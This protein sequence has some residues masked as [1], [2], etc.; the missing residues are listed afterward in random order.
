MASTK[1]CL[2]GHIPYFY[3][4]LREMDTK[5]EMA[6]RKEGR[7]E[8][9]RLVVNFAVLLLSRVKARFARNNILLQGVSNVCNIKHKHSKSL[10]LQY[11]YGCPVFLLLML[12][13][14]YLAICAWDGW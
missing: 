14:L 5:N 13:A 6:R 12:N 4:W 8:E 10:F 11:V 9:R 2:T 3:S 7:K 1:F